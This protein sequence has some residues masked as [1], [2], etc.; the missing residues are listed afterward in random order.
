[1]KAALQKEERRTKLRLVEKKKETASEPPPSLIEI[2]EYQAVLGRKPRQGFFRPS[3]LFGCDRANVFAYQL[4][5]EGP[6]NIDNKLRRVLD[7][8]HAIH[9]LIQDEYLAKH[10]DYWFVKEPKVE[11]VIRGARVKGSCDGVVIRRSD[12][13]RFGVEI[14]TI[15]HDEFMR[16]TGP[17]E[18]HVFQSNLY[19]N[20]QKLPWITVL[21]WD[22]DKQHMK[23]YPVKRDKAMWTEVE[24]RVE[25]LHSFIERDKLPK[26]DKATC[27]KQ[28]CRFVDHCRRKGAPV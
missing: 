18:E 26:Y 10:P 21:Y 24:D 5:R 17:K 14:K 22:K 28:F 4:V 12:M 27:N 9:D 16:L 23:E 8:G 19:M 6:Q 25:Y 15:N 11:L 2:I 7:T 20:M 13:F 1:M 3:S